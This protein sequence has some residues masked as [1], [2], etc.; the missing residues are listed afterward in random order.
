[1]CVCDFFTILSSC[2]LILFYAHFHFEEN[3]SFLSLIMVRISSKNSPSRIQENPK[4]SIQPMEINSHSIDQSTSSSKILHVVRQ[5]LLN[6]AEELVAQQQNLNENS[7]PFQ[8]FEMN[9]SP[10][11]NGNSIKKKKL[12]RKTK[13]NTRRK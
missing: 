11:R 13:K 6:A 9:K 10:Q 12:I 8:T 5:A 3:F 1:M 4:S 2:S 7:I